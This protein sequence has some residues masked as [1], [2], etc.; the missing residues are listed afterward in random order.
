MRGRGDGVGKGLFLK[1]TALGP[2]P[3]AKIQ[4]TP[5]FCK[6]FVKFEEET[7]FLFLHPLEKVTQFGVLGLLN[8]EVFQTL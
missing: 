1:L 4:Q 6:G 3:F 8:Q 2:T 7:F 5:V